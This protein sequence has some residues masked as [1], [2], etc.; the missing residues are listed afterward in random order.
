MSNMTS[1]ARESFRNACLHILRAGVVFCA[2]L[3]PAWAGPSAAILVY[4]RF[5]PQV[6]DSMTTRS[7]VFIAQLTELRRAGYTVVPLSTVVDGL[8]GRISLPPKAVAITIDDGHRS[9]YTEL[10]PIIRHERLPVTLFIYPSAISNASY[11]MTWAQLQDMLASGTVD[12][13]S[14]TYWHPDFRIERQRLAPDAYRQFV[15]TQLEKPRQVLKTRLGI[16]ATYLAW[17]FGIHDA[18]LENA[19]RAAGYRAAFTLGERHAT[20]HDSPLALP[21]YLIVDARGVDG[22]VRSLQAG[23]RAASGARQP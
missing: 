7:N 19:A 20:S 5:G 15:H 17:P 16:E 14:H 3:A 8:A 2:F 18:D 10:L 11:A 12:I 1:R 22:L 21:R 4:H 6:A 23:E 9:V 13:Q